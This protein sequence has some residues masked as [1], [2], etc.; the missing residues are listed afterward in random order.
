MK[1]IQ[2]QDPTIDGKVILERFLEKW[3]VKM[4][5]EFICFK[6]GS[7]GGIFCAR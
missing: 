7:D 3:D 4:L 2:A 6:V 5:T 1:N